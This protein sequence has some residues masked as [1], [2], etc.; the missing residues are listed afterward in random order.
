MGSRHRPARGSYAD[1]GS[2]RADIDVGLGVLS[3]HRTFGPGQLRNALAVASRHPGGRAVLRAG[4]RAARVSYRSEFA[5]LSDRYELPHLLNQRRLLGCGAEIGVA[6]GVFSEALLSLWRGRHLIS[7]DPWAAATSDE[8]RDTGNLE[9]S[10][11]DEYYQ[12]TL[13]RLSVF[14]PRS[15]VWRMFGS[16]GAERIPHHSLDFVYIDARHDYE[17]VREDVREWFEKVRPGGIIAG[18]DYV[19][20]MTEEGEFGVRRAVDEFFSE[21]ELRVRSTFADPHSPTWLVLV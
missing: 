4:K 6:R 5:R 1:E 13:S 15:S 8:Y 7:I 10:E 18:H 20:G 3:T 16:D 9:Q 14:G 11:H 19:D 21:R 17:S 2:T 12:D